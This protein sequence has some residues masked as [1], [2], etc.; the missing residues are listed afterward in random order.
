[1]RLKTYAFHIG[2][3]IPILIYFNDNVLGISTVSGCTSSYSSN[4]HTTEQGNNSNNNITDNSNKKWSITDKSIVL[5]NKLASKSYENIKKDNV[6]V[7]I[8]PIEPN[9]LILRKVTGIAGDFVWQIVT[10][11]DFYYKQRIH[12]NDNYLWIESLS[13]RKDTSN[14]EIE[15]DSREYQQVSSGLVEGIAIGTIWP[16]SRWTLY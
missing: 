12:I 16:P 5:T 2:S 11:G 15:E 1:M 7:L 3:S 6:I 14:N 9:R 4:N 10:D 13:D 8:D